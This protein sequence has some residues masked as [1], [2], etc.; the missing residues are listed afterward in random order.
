MVVSINGGTSWTRTP[1]LYTSPVVY[2]RSVAKPSFTNAHPPLCV[3]Y[4]TTQFVPPLRLWHVGGTAN[5][6]TI[7]P[8]YYSNTDASNNITWLPATSNS[9]INPFGTCYDI[10]YK[11]FS[12]SGT[13]NYVAVGENIFG[14]SNI[15]Y[16]I[17]GVN[18]FSS[19]NGNSFKPRSVTWYNGTWVAVGSVSSSP[20]NVIAHSSNGITWTNSLNGDGLFQNGALGV[21]SAS[22]S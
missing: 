21:G 10:A 1:A 19:S 15:V 11:P 6:S 2:P 7:S 22:G 20:L 17:D 14:V 13:T 5:G 18:W 16:S 3:L 4:S 8:I 12:F 9:I